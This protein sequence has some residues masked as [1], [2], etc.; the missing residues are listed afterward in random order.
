MQI[1]IELVLGPAGAVVVLLLWIADLRKQRDTLDARLS[2]I[3]DA[4]EAAMRK[5]DPP[6]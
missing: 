6:K 3:V 5:V 2:R 4:L 1:P